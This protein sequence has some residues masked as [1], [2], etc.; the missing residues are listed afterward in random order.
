MANTATPRGARYNGLFYN[1]VNNRLA[2]YHRGTLAGYLSGND[3]VAADD[4][5]VSGDAVSI[6]GVAYTWPSADGSSTNQLTTNGSGT[7]AWLPA[8]DG[9]A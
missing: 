6:N 2:L 7:L 1:A 3:I 5:T 8:D 9:A 4:L